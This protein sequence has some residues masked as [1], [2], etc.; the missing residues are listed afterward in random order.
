MQPH[1]IA[2]ESF[3]LA[4]EISKYV[5]QCGEINKRSRSNILAKLRRGIV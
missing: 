4:R 1:S 3:V 2:G 5:L